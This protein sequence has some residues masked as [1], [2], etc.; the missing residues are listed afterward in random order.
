MWNKHVFNNVL[1]MDLEHAR[2]FT[3]EDSSTEHEVIKVAKCKQNNILTSI[4]NTNSL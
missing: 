4:Q 3:T 1:I 2:C